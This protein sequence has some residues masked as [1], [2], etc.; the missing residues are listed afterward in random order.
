MAIYPS[1][2]LDVKYLYHY[3]VLRGG[4]LAFRYCQGTKQQSYTAKL[5]KLLPI[6]LPPSV[7]EQRAIAALLS[8]MDAEIATLEAE[9]TKTRTLK[10]GMMQKLLTGEIRLI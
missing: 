2:E 10:Q 1:P 6:C 7:D 3:Y 4:E 9:L 5:V 8:D